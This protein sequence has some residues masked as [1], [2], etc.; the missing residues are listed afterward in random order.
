MTV[1]FARRFILNHP[2]ARYKANHRH[3]TFLA[4]LEVVEQ[5]KREF[6]SDTGASPSPPVRN[7]VFDN[8]NWGRMRR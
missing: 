1:E 7:V 4:A 6:S 8:P 5:Y 2:E 3:A